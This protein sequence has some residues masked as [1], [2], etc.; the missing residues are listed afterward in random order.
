MPLIGAVA[1]DLTGAM[2]TG[3]LL[4]RSKA[5]TAVFFNEQAALRAEGVSE[6]DAILISSN[7][8]PLLPVNAKRYV[9]DATVAL[10]NMGVKYFSKR[11]DTTLR[12]GIGHEIDAMMDVIGDDVVAVVVPAMPQSRRILVGG[13]SIIDSVSLIRTPVAQDVRTPVKENYIPDLLASQTSRKT[14]L[15]ELRDVLAG[16]AAV[17]AKL[18]EKRAEGCEVIIVDAVSIEDVKVIADAC[19]EL[20]WNVLAVDPGPFTAKMAQARG[21]I[22]EESANIPAV[23]PVE[24]K[25]VLIAAGSATPVTKKQMEVLCKDERNVR[26]SVDPIP[27]ING[28]EEAQ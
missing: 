7:S 3:D 28:A 26:I 17:K 19:V 27:L 15:V 4:A 25:T 21:L 20:D 23:A 18:A 12:G 16:T 14:G 13:Y 22:G 8:R 11:I 5:R 10:K 24:G 2:T 1:D 6:L 9:G